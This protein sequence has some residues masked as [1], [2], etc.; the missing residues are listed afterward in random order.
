MTVPSKRMLVKIWTSSNLNSVHYCKYCTTKRTKQCA[1]VTTEIN[2][3]SDDCFTYR[4][5]CLRRWIY[6]T[7]REKKIIWKKW[8]DTRTWL[9]LFM[10]LYTFSD[11]EIHSHSVKSFSLSTKRSSVTNWN[12]FYFW[13]SK[14]CQVNRL[15]MLLY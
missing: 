9:G 8:I 13:M 15:K 11:D 10:S 1:L 2:I 12:L 3:Y 5:D 7:T 14:K 4:N 6:E